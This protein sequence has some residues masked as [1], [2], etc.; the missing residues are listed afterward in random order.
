MR[1]TRTLI[2]NEAI[3]IPG[4]PESTARVEVKYVINAQQGQIFIIKDP[5]SIKTRDKFPYGLTVRKWPENMIVPDAKIGM[6]RMD[7]LE[8]SSI[9]FD[10]SEMEPPKGWAWMDDAL[11]DHLG[12]VSND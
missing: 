4:T 5:E 11:E 7:D 6:V 9:D 12:E 3:P 2:T 8:S 10:I 1:I